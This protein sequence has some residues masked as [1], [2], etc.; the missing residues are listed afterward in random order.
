L[1]GASGNATG[2]T[3][4]DRALAVGADGAGVTAGAG[5]GDVATVVGAPQAARRNDDSK[6]NEDSGFMNDLAGLANP[7]NNAIRMPALS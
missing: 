3:S 1:R 7:K 2:G 6:T 5:V 4:V